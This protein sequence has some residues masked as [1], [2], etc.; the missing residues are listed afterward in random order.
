[1]AS[2]RSK[3]DVKHTVPHLFIYSES[4]KS[5]RTQAGMYFFKKLAFLYWESSVLSKTTVPLIFQSFT[6]DPAY[7]KWL[8]RRCLFRELFSILHT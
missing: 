5:V 3:F 1:L 4:L 2:F 6:V 7:F 8:L